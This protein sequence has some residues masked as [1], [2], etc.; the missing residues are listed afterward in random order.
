M[1]EH[2][3]QVGELRAGLQAHMAD[4]KLRVLVDGFMSHYDELFRLKGV[5]AKADVFHFVS[6]MWKTPAD[7]CFMCFRSFGPSL[8]IPQLEPLTE[9]QLLGICSRH[10]RP[11]RGRSLARDGS[12]IH[13]LPG[14][15]GNSP[16]VANYMGQMAMAMGKLD[17]V[18]T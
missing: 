13:W 11:S 15:L 16:N 3:R 9:Q 6:G 14:S 18:R 1:E 10:S 7:R 2:Q 5:A 17:I 4:N 12:S 8:L